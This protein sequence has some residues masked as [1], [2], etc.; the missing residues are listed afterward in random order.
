MRSF[1]F[2]LIALLYGC[3][4]SEYRY[5][6]SDYDIVVY[7]GTSAGV[8]AAVQAKRMG[9]SVAIVCPDTHLGGLSAGG[10]G[11]TDSGSKEVIG[12]LARRKHGNGRNNLNTETK[13]KERRQSMETIAPCGS[14]N[15]MSQKPYSKTW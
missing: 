13:D 12:G 11:W 10:L 7:G 4:P 15:R 2:L 14:S 9:K 6:T 5:K 1:Q 3:S 8:I